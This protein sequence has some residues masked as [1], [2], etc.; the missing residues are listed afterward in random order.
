MENKKIEDFGEHIGGA[1]KDMYACASR[2]DLSQYSRSMIHTA[3][4]KDA[5]PSITKKDEADPF[6]RLWKQKMR[7]LLRKA[8][9]FPS[10]ADEETE[11]IILEKYYSQVDAWKK[12]VMSVKSEDDIAA[13]YAACD[14]LMPKDIISVLGVYGSDI[15]R[16]KWSHAKWKRQA[17]QKECRSSAPSSSIKRR[18]SRFVPAQMEHLKRVG[19]DWR[20]GRHVDKADWLE[21]LGFRA[22][23]FGNWLSQLDRQ[24]NMDMAYDAFMDLAYVLNV[25]PDSLAFGQLAIAFGSRGRGGALAHY[26]PA[27]EVIALTKMKGA[28]SLAHEEFHAIDDM[29]A[30]KNSKFGCLASELRCPP[31][32]ELEILREKMRYKDD[33]SYTDFYRNSM[34]FDVC[35]SKSDNG[36]WRSPCE[37]MARAFACYVSDRLAEKGMQND[38]LC[39]HSELAVAFDGTAAFPQGEER[40]LINKAFDDL[41]ESIKAEGLMTPAEEGDFEMITSE[42]D[43]DEK[44]K[45]PEKASAISPLRSENEDGNEVLLH[46]CPDGQMC[47]IL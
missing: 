41:F 24:T 23:E 1:R 35:Y 2:G 7:G 44:E 19:P 40:V 47:F 27:A 3:E 32:R 38:Y 9:F 31:V 21:T 43:T 46:E 17:M 45:K 4:V 26:E 34:R 42:V 14:E 16:A 28:G 13:V 22:G 33:Y 18:K 11:K 10:N 8:P 15:N 12:L 5:W 20:H 25:T 29:I 39:G 6:L 30:K 36:Y 37:M